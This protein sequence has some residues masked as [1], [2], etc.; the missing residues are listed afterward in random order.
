MSWWSLQLR[1]LEQL[2]TYRYLSP[3]Q[4]ILAWY[5]KSKKTL[6][7][8]LKSLQERKLCNKTAYTYSQLHGRK[9]DIWHLL[10]NG[11][12]VLERLHGFTSEWIKVSKHKVKL[13]E[14]YI[15]R[16]MIISSHIVFRQALQKQG[17]NL[18]LYDYDF[19]KKKKMNGKG[20]EGATKISTG[21]S[22]LKSDAIFMTQAGNEA[23]LFCVEIHNQ[24]RV[25]KLTK[26]LRPY[27][28]VLAQ[29]TASQKYHLNKN[30][31]ILILFEKESTLRTSLELVANDSFYLYLRE[32][33][34]FKTIDNFLICPLQNWINLN[35]ESVHLLSLI[36]PSWML[37][38][39]M[40]TLMKPDWT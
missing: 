5:T 38:N 6:R 4:F 28:Y 24:H 11:A 25:T 27:A 1:I 20:I 30:P 34:L 39:E 17:I 29:G 12:E 26:Q 21:S 22:F 14:D 9:E 23:S 37:W 13:V 19:E 32:Y 8:N 18:L 40:N 3:N 36:T 31:R 7:D 10:P 15:H 16:K 35:K 2:A 33:F